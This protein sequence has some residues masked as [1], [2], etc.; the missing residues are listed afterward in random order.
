MNV[1][2]SI[3][4][5]NIIKFFNDNPKDLTNLIPESKK[6]EFFEKIKVFAIKNVENGEDN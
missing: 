3:Y 1:D 2:V 5:N 4:L 6:T